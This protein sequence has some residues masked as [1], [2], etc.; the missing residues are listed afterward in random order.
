MTVDA[1]SNAHR[2]REVPCAPY[3]ISPFIAALANS[4]EALSS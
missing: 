1:K 4:P 2:V 3:L